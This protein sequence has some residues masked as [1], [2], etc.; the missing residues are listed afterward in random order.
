MTT[1][2]QG[3]TVTINLDNNDQVT[4]IGNGNVTVTPVTGSSYQTYLS[5]PQILG[6]YGVY[7]TLV[8]KCTSGGSYTSISVVSN[9]TDNPVFFQSDASGNPIGLITPSGT[10]SIANTYTWAQLQALTGQTAGNR[11]YISDVGNAEFIYDGTRWTRTTPL[12][13]LGSGIPFV[14]QSSCTIGAAT[15]TA[16]ALTGLT[17][18]AGLSLT[19]PQ[20]CYMYFTGASATSA[21][22]VSGT[23][24]YAVITAATTATLYSN[25]YSTGI[26]VIPAAPAN[27]VSLAG[28][29]YT[30]GV[31]VAYLGPNVVVPANML[32]INGSLRFTSTWVGY[33]GQSYTYTGFGA[34][35]NLMGSGVLTGTGVIDSQRMMR[36]RGV[37]NRQ[38]AFQSSAWSPAL[39]GSAG[40]TYLAIDSTVAQV[41]SFGM[42]VTIAGNWQVLDAYNIEILPS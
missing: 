15:N 42:Q 9:K 14:M 6:P 13:L 36:N 26:P 39:N 7:T 11:A 1:F 19:Y 5:G 32:G 27:F 18:M 4:F 25:T 24:Y 28:G 29:A 31:A 3:D 22:L 37:A 23:W 12:Q 17:T 35:S 34:I 8:I 41:A 16:S 10:I 30:Q 21:G 20:P 40:N 33:S 38:V 2:N